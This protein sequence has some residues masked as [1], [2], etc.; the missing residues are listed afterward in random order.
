MLRPS[1]VPVMSTCPWLREALPKKNGWQGA[2]NGWVCEERHPEAE[3]AMLWVVTFESTPLRSG[4]AQLT[5]TVS[6][7]VFDVVT[8]L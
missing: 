2:E 8:L 5:C 7:N 6:R 1:M 4:L 3:Y